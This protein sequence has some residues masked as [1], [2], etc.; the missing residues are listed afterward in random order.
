MTINRVGNGVNPLA[1][2][3]QKGKNAKS[4]KATLNSPNDRIEIS[5]EAKI[6]SSEISDPNKL[7]VIK[8]RIKS[9]YYNQEKVIGSVADSIL[10]ELRGA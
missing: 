7:N 10:K 5:E 2:Y 6:K 3:S 8:D 4:S 1:D 9:G